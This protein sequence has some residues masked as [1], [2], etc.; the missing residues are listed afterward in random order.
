MQM[1]DFQ[2]FWIRWW[3]HPCRWASI[4]RP[5]TISAVSPR[6][7][8]VNTFPLKHI[9]HPRWRRRRYERGFPNC[10]TQGWTLEFGWNPWH[11]SMSSWTFLTMQIMPVSMSICKLPNIILWHNGL[12]LSDISEF[13]DYMTTS[14]NE[15]IPPLED[16]GYWKYYG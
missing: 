4:P 11:T 7:S 6:C 5:N 13:E 14:S 12:E 15:D 8:S 10:T 16:V 2:L 1:P 9:H 3:W